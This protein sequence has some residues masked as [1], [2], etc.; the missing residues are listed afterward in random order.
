MNQRLQVVY[1][2]YSFHLNR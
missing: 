1:V 2:A